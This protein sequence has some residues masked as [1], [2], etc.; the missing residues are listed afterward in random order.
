MI[1]GSSKRTEQE[2]EGERGGGRRGTGGK[3]PLLPFIVSQATV[4][5]KLRQNANNK[6]GQ[7]PD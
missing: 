1:E 3:Q 7:E 2:Q 5:Q 4:G 6:N